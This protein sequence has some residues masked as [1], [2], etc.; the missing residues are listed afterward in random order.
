[1]T[2]LKVIYIALFN[3]ESSAALIILPFVEIKEKSIVY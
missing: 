2:F 1:M 3:F